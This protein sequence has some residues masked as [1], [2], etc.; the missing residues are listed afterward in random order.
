MDRSAS[1]G[2]VHVVHVFGGLGPG[3]QGG[4]ERQA[5]ALIRGCDPRE[6]R[7]TAIS[8]T[9]IHAPIARDLAGVGCP[10]LALPPRPGKTPAYVARLARLLRRL[11]PDIVHT[12]LDA[13]GFWGRAAAVLAGAPAIVASSRTMP[14]PTRLWEPWLDRLLSRATAARI[15]NSEA[16]RDGLVA[17]IGLPAGSVDVIPNG[18]ETGRLRASGDRASCRLR[19]GLP[20][21]A[22]V[23]LAIGRLRE[24][25]CDADPRGR[26]AGPRLSQPAPAGGGG[27]AARR[28][29][30]RSGPGRGPV[31]SRVAAGSARRRRGPPGGRRR[32]RAALANRGLAERAAGGDVVRSAGCR[33]AAPS[34]RRSGCGTA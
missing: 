11:A 7:H 17:R 26:R 33:L 2:R 15:A 34:H 14:D 31:R 30:R 29:A 16:V 19:L 9:P 20:T 10:T 8:D 24:G 3:P 22:H 4:T 27:R 6:Y 5:V 23:V 1:D 12:W 21:D 13:P 32:I 28:R 18:F 25:S